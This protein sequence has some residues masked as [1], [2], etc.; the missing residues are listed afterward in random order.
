[1]EHSRWNFSKIYALTLL[2]LCRECKLL[3]FLDTLVNFKY[4]ILLSL[5]NINYAN[6]N[7]NHN[8]QVTFNST[9]GDRTLFIA[10]LLRI[11]DNGILFIM[12]LRHISIQKTGYWIVHMYVVPMMPRVL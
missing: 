3:L 11:R 7:D 10:S 4:F 1:M 8:D 6:I 2:V 12:Y 5:I 9:S